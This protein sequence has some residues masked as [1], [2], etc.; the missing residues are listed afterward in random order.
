MKTFTLF[1]LTGESEIVTGRDISEAV[2]KN[3]GGGAMK[4]LDFWSHGDN[5]DKYYWDNGKR[6]WHS[7]I[8]KDPVKESI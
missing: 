7:N 3:Y 2:N 4:A 6:T 8:M 1:W 5:R